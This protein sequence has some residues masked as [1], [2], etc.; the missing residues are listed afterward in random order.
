MERWHY[1]GKYPSFGRQVTIGVWEKDSFRGAVVFARGANKSIGSPYGLEQDECCE[2]VRVALRAHETPVTRIIR[3]ALKLLKDSSPGLRLIV[4]YADEA[5]GHV[6]KVYQAGNWLYVGKTEQSFLKIR[7]KVL[8]PKTVHSRYGSGSQSLAWI[9]A[10]LDP[11][12]ERV[13]LGAKHKYLMPLDAEMRAYIE[14][15]TRPYPKRAGS[16]DSDATAIPGGQGRCNSDLGALK[17]V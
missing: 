15:L 2:L 4:S 13:M 6:G 10:N 9:R 1:S 3:I 11:K 14:P 8:H 7:G 12:A 5:Q 16:I 17:V